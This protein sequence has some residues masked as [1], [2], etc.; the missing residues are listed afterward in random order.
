M[1][2]PTY[3]KLGNDGRHD[4]QNLG[5]SSI[6]Y[7]AVVVEENGFKKSWDNVGSNHL[8]IISLL[9]IGLNKLQDLFL[10]CS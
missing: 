9:D 10:Y 7:I 5:V 3:R 6:W 4:L 1:W 8:E 2:G